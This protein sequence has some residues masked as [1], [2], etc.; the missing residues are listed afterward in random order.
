MSAI[1]GATIGPLVTYLLSILGLAIVAVY[2]IFRLNSTQIIREKVWSAFVGDKDFNDEKLK[3]SAHD[4]L[5]LTRF[6]VVYGVPARS[7]SDL[8]RLLSW[9]DR[10]KFTPIDVKRAR[11]WIDPSKDEPLEAPSQRYFIT[12]AV[13]LMI[14]IASFMFVSNKATGSKTTMLRMQVSKTWIW[15]D[16]ASVESVLGKHWRIDAESCS[17]HTLPDTTI[18]GLTDAETTAI[19]NGIANGKL[20]AAVSDG[21]KYQ[22]GSLLVIS[23]FILFLGISVGLSLHFAMLARGLVRQLRSSEDG[24]SEQSLLPAKA[25]P[26]E[27]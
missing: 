4:Q 19:C 2:A 7:I 3:S 18:T 24:P 9:M 1:L 11:R 14:M 21:L 23:F 6:R 16:G 5:D 20:K 27:Q 10:C 15:S 26:I 22:S 13:A 25:N 8:H 17:K 12:C